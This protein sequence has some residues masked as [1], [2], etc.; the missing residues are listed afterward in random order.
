MVVLSLKFVG[1]TSEPLLSNADI[2]NKFKD[3][4]IIRNT[5]VTK[6]F[7]ILIQKLLLKSIKY[8]R[9]LMYY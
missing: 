5:I 6:N 1:N 2:D 3:F 8:F 4:D 7:F 9:I